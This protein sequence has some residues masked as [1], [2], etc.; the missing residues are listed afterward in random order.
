V[1]DPATSEE[2]PVWVW[3]GIGNQAVR[4]IRFVDDDW[5]TFYELGILPKQCPSWIEVSRAYSPMV[6]GL[7][8]DKR[9]YGFALGKD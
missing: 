1:E 3:F 6:E 2:N 9:L 5:H 4:L 7:S 8:M